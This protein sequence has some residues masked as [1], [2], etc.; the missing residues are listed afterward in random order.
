MADGLSEARLLPRVL[1]SAS[2]GA[3][4]ILLHSQVAAAGQG[5][6]K[7]STS[8][9]ELLT[10]ADAALAAQ[11]VGELESLR[12]FFLQSQPALATS[13][14]QLRIVAFSS[15][16]EFDEFRTNAHSPA[17]FVGGPDQP[18]IV[19][20]RLSKDTLP[21]LR[22]EYV[23]HVLRST[24][25]SMGRALPLWLEEGLAEYYAGVSPERAARRS[26]L[27]QGDG[28]IPLR[29]LL[30]ADRKSDF[31]R[32]ADLAERYYAES[33]AMVDW[34]MRQGTSNARVD[35]WATELPAPLDEMEAALRHHVNS[36]RG[37][38]P[39]P[40]HSAVVDPQ[41]LSDTDVNLALARVA[42]RTGNFSEARARLDRLPPTLPQAWAIRGEF[43]LKRGHR[44]EARM[45]L[46]EALWRNG[47]DRLALWRLA[48]LEQ[49]SDDGNAVP[50][51]ER[52]VAT[53]P[54]FDDARLVLSSHYLRQQRY[55]EAL[56][57]LRN[58]RMAPPDKADYFQRA[59]ALA[60]S[61]VREGTASLD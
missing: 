28:W 42:L 14:A 40:S 53:D 58:V 43:E 47:A 21:T 56:D 41:P 17:Y 9:L 15:E 38:V 13:P 6:I 19:L 11:A 20:G 32:Q 60:E 24:G 39:P 25:R 48:V 51:L 45:A 26:R 1:T 44:Q 33:W 46:W 7:V 52:L 10:S 3:C 27:L 18:T 30:A 37:S 8:S 5:W 50:V 35:R 4:L 31:Y 57:Q 16:W 36:L 34:L 29:E 22:H 55:P 59:L 49:S 61:R 12:I 23:H 54:A 2:L